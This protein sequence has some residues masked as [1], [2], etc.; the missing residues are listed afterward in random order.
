MKRLLLLA[1]TIG[2]LC[3]A[4]TSALADGKGRRHGHDGHGHHHHHDHDDDH[5]HHRRGKHRGWHK[6]DWRRGDR[7]EVVHIERRYYVDDYAHYHLR[8]PPSGHRWI[9]SPEGR[10]ILVAVATGIIADVLLHH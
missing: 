5:H 3:L 8:R 10:F 7:I 1:A 4:S 9:R 2:C 6:S